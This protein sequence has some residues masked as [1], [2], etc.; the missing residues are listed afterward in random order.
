MYFRREI[1]ETLEQTCSSDALDKS[2]RASQE[3]ERFGRHHFQYPGAKLET[4][5]RW[6]P[7]LA[8]GV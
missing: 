8:S 1:S 6:T 3:I 7:R 4:S 5:R 2:K